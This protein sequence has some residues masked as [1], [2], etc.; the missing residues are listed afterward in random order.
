MLVS[1]LRI[2][3]RNGYFERREKAK[4][5][6][7]DLGLRVLW[8]SLTH[9][10][11]PAD[12]VEGDKEVDDAEDEHEDGAEGGIVSMIEATK[13]DEDNDDVKDEGHYSNQSV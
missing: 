8:Q 10:N 2:L 4:E 3:F 7:H 5:A 9:C 13:A 11:G 6:H 12:E 1:D